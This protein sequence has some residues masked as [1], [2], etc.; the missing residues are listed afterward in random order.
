MDVPSTPTSLK[1]N[2]KIIEKFSGSEVGW[3]YK[4]ISLKPYGQKGLYIFKYNEEQIIKEEYNKFLEALIYK[5][6]FQNK[7]YDA[8]YIYMNGKHI[9]TVPANSNKTF[10]ISIYEY[11]Q[12]KAVQAEGYLFYPDEVVWTLNNNQ[13]PHKGQEFNIIYK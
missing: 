11:G 8:Q 6:N 3:I 10:S 12:L 2:I 5:V 1:R 13:Q 9:G 4:D 7:K